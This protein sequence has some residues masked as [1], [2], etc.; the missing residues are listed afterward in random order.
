[1]EFFKVIRTETTEQNIQELLSLEAL[2]TYSNLLFNLEE[3]KENESFIGGVWGEFTLSRNLVK[4]GVRFAL[5]DCPNA[6]CWTVTTGYPPA[7]KSIVIHLTINRQQKE[8]EFIEEL[9]AFL[10]DHSQCLY[11]LFKS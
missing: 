6:L 7:E 1:M 9:E 3:A 5:V 10:E 8:P 2:E 11:A 4:G